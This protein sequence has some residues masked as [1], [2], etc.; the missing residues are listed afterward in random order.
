MAGE[1]ILAPVA[2]GGAE[3]GA[4]WE[5][6][7]AT[8]EVI[9]DSLWRRRLVLL[10]RYGWPVLALLAFLLFPF[11]WLST[12][13]PAYGTVFDMVFRSDREHFIG[14]TTL[15]FIVG[16]LILAY[17]PKLRYRLHWYLIG[18]VIVALM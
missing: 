4:R 14:H 8:P 13:W 18:L 6:T 5:H 2:M 9:G 17:M 10:L 1:G 16:T 11:D 12:V 7:M 3:N 15:F